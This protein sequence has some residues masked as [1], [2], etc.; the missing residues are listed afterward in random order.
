MAEVKAV[1][2]GEA[3]VKARSLFVAGIIGAVVA[4]PIERETE[5]RSGGA[6]AAG[7]DLA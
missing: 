4:V 2:E 7:G 3:V 1:G 5:R 6:T